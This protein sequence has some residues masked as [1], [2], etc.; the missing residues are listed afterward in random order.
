MRQ[1]VEDDSAAVVGAFMDPEMANQTD[2][3]IRNLSDATLWIE[4]RLVDWTSG[5][6]YSWAV[7]DGGA[8]VGSVSVTSIDLRH[9]S[10]WVSY[11]TI[12]EFR[13]RGLIASATRAVAQW[14]FDDLGLFRLEL[15]HRTNNPAS[16]GVALAAGFVV[17][18]VE[19]QKLTY[20]GERFDVE[21]HARLATDQFTPSTIDG[22]SRI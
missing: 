14:A 12:P 5:T 6:G 7:I 20:E 19:R 15:G 8:V 4:H 9:G 3:A 21:L 1:W 16:C 18:G 11:W 17:E 22:R 2:V 13:G 10:G